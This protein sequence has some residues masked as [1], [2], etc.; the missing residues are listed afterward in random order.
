MQ[1]EILIPQGKKNVNKSIKAIGQELIRRADDITNDI[2]FV[3]EISIN[4]K[5]T[6]DEVVN[7]E[8][9]KKYTAMFEKESEENVDTITYIKY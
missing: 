7:F 1:K 4:A 5:I 3:R 2:E 8:V 6:S 9:T